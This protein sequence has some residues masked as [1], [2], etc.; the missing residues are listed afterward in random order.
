M[1][2]GEASVEA[3]VHVTHDTS[4]GSIAPATGSVPAGGSLSFEALDAHGHPMEA[5]WTL[6]PSTCGEMVPAHGPTSALQAA[7][8]AGGLTCTVAAAAGSL[9]LLATV[10]VAHGAA[11]SISISVGAVPAGGSVQATATVRDGAGASLD[12]ALVQWTTTC[13]GVSP[14]QGERTT[15]SAAAGAGGTTCTVTAALG[16]L[17]ATADVVVGYAGPFTITVAPSTGSLRP[18]QSQVLTVTA[19]DAAGNEVPVDGVEW[20]APCGTIEGT[21]TTVTYTAG[22]GA[23]NCDV[24]ATVSVGGTSTSGTA[25]LAIEAGGDS[26]MLV[27]AGAAAAAGA[28]ALGLGLMR[29]RKQA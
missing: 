21:G 5:S 19:R 17:T 8:T 10:A 29:R 11:A 15:V 6:S 18:G 13:A 12:G 23:G 9:S 3:L 24:T 4:S 22:A 20:N 25:A 27:G 2:V 14:A 16:A 28:G 26:T 1:E 7:P